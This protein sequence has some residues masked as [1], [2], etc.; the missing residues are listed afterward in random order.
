MKPASPVALAMVVLSAAAV[1]APAQVSEQEQARWIRWA[2]PLPK[3]IA[4]PRKVVLPASEV[5]L[6]VVG[7]SGGPTQTAAQELRALFKEKAK[8]DLSRGRFEIVLGVCDAA[9]RLGG[10]AVPDAARLKSLP[11]PEQAYL[12]RPVGENRLALAALDPRGAYYAAQTL[13]QL[14]EAQFDEG[15]VAVPLAV[16][17]DW[18]DLEWRGEWGGSANRDVVWMSHLK[19]NRVESHVRL[20]MTKDGRGTAHADQALI[21]LSRAHALNLVPIIT[22]LNGLRRTGIYKFYPQLQGKGKSAGLKDHS[23]LIA[24]CCADPKIAEIFGDWMAAL[25]SQPGVTDV[26]A[27]LTETHQHCS[28]PA[29]SKV[30]QWAFEARRLVQGWRLARKKCP[31]LHLSILLTQGSYDTNDKV[32][33]E[34]PP[35]VGVT[36]YDGGRTYDSSRDPMIYPLLEKYAAKG[37][38]LGCYP[39][40]TASWRI[41]CPWSGPQFIK[42]RM[43]EF[44]DK[45]LRA[46]VGYATPNNKLYEF[47]I[48]AAAEWSWNAHGRSER[49][50]ALAYWTR[51]RVKDPEAAADW[52]MML[53]PVGWDVYGSRI[54]AHNFFGRAASLVANRVRP[55]LGKKGMFRY[56]P[57]AARIDQDLAIC[58]RAMALAQRVGDPHMILETRVIRGYVQMIKSIYEIC[59]RVSRSKLPPYPVRVELQQ[60]LNALLLAAA[61]ISDALKQWELLC[62]DGKR[63]GGS[64]L[65]DTIDVTQKTAADIADSLAALGLRNPLK[66]YLRNEIGKWKTNDFDQGG[67]ITKTF[68][69]TDVLL[70]PGEYEVGFKYTGGWNGL[71]IYGVTLVSAPADDPTQRT[72]I[73]KDIHRGTA[74]HRN[75]ANVYRVTLK[76]RDPKLRY[77]ILADIR[78]ACRFK[79]PPDKQG[80]NG[81]VWMQT[82]RPADWRKLVEQAKPLTDEQLAEQQAAR[83]SGKGLRVGVLPG[84]YGARGV[85]KALRSAKGVD[86]QPIGGL[87][88]NV[89]RACQVVVLPQPKGAALGRETVRA[90][91][92]FVRAGGGLVVTHDA[93]GYRGLPAIIPQVCKKGVAHARDAQ[94]IV[95]AK[96][97]V[98]R[99]LP[100]NQALPHAYYDHIELAAGPKGVVLAKAAK[101]GKPVVIAGAFGKG[102]YVACGLAIGLNADTKDAPPTGAEKTLLVNAVRW[103]ARAGK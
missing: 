78:G 41:V 96:H 22:H 58:D 89:L 49:E 79:R 83:F 68:D 88:A 44:V 15:R 48:T 33:A 90:L 1:A 31:H 62:G 91:R 71:G 102:R 92:A 21:D 63:I 75:K 86:A 10:L 20:T 19:M 9:G 32:L 100:L 8:A 27:W 76:R 77:F 57:T 93:V 7:K 5:K 47:N 69:V 30:G 23:R 59:T 35:E 11:H 72:V 67:R 54:P 2:I 28:C 94:W 81:V 87:Y 38:W 42:F 13:K 39:Q 51:Q 85:L 56:F 103:C 45:K 55:K 73:S 17:T 53:G 29:C 14:L 95:V 36:Y 16:V 61:D 52:A 12:I 84:G 3:E 50:F 25:G 82:R 4:I 80:C 24:P 99:G 26:C 46:L 64:R 65:V 98:T 18:P 43:T 74:A 6:R 101:S 66:P 70:A 60:Q 97:P 40:L 37:G 34:I